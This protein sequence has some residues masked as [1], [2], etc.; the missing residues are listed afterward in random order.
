MTQKP[1]N[2]YTPYP[3]YSPNQN[4]PS[5]LPLSRVEFPRFNGKG[6]QDWWYKV[7]QFFSFDEVQSQQK[8]TIAALHFDDAAL[9]WNHAYMRSRNHLP[10][11]T[12]KECIYALP[13]R[14]GVEF[15]DPMSE[16]VSLR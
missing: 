2:L 14:F 11:P 12:W 7:D 6:F 1:P 9:Q 3:Q 15:D 13:D 4:N 8:V 10:S 5:L 16:L